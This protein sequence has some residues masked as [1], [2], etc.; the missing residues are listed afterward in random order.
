MLIYPTLH[1]KSLKI[2]RKLIK[3]APPDTNNTSLLVTLLGSYEPPR[4]CD[5]RELTADDIKFLTFQRPNVPL[6]PID[7]VFLIF[8][9]TNF[10]HCFHFVANTIASEKMGCTNACT[11]SSIEP[12]IPSVMICLCDLRKMCDVFLWFLSVLIK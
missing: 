2:C 3:Q 10:M 4:N 7:H 6:Q 1:F 5:I 8:C 11:K 9:H 12:A